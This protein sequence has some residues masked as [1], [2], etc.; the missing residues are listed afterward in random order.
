M[1]HKKAITALLFSAL[2]AIS[3]VIADDLLDGPNPN[4]F[5]ISGNH[6]NRHKEKT[7]AAALGLRKGTEVM[8]IGRNDNTLTVVE[9]PR[10]ADARAFMK[11]IHDD[12]FQ[13]EVDSV[14]YPDPTMEAETEVR[15][16]RNLAETVPWGISRVFEDASG[17]AQ[18]PT[19]FP[20]SVTKPIC[21]IDSGY[22]VS[23]PDLPNTASNAD[24]TQGVGSS[25][26]FDVDGCAH[27]SHVSGTI[28]ASGNNGIGVIGVFPDAPEIK[29]VKVFG[30]NGSTSCTWSYT[31]SLIK[32]AEDCR[33]SGAK[34]ITMS[35][36]GGFSSQA[37]SAAFQSF[38]DIDGILS[39]AAAGN[40]G[41]TSYSYP[42]SYSSVMSVGATDVNNNIA[43]F[44]QHNSEVDISAPGVSVRSTTGAS[45]YSNY[46]GTSMATPHVSAVA[47]LLWNNYPQCTNAEIR[48]ALEQ[49]ATDKGEA[50]RDDYFGWGIVNYYAARSYVTSPQGCA[51]YSGPTVSPVPTQ[52]PQP[53]AAPT[54]C[55]DSPT[56][57]TDSDGWTCE[58]YGSYDNA[59]SLWGDG[60]AGVDGKTANEACCVCGGGDKG[61][62]PNPPDDETCQDTDQKFLVNDTEKHCRWALKYPNRRC[63]DFVTDLCPVTCGQPCTPVDTVGRFTLPNNTLKSC[64]WA[65]RN[66]QKR[67]RN[68]VVYAN[69]PVTCSSSGTSTV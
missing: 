56:G 20:S 41:N 63:S 21:V 49:S 11:Q 55:T 4:R 24:P 46:S 28:A 69:C 35:L 33:A 18:L 7:I 57:W 14:I 37:E 27:G 54:T 43:S 15:N 23:H 47:L 31:S 9:L 64:A 25:N 30:T 5:I 51:A 60:Y 67:C 1:F 19:T 29:V 8:K 16:L 32:A 48:E 53:T 62:G 34:I 3:K 36:G 22:Q 39:I 38:F 50:G 13:I 2:G 52:A 26:S 59:C 44:S 10:D 61:G 65:S 58:Q 6:A 68:Y 12:G 40:G 66:I 45:G 42:A 17:N